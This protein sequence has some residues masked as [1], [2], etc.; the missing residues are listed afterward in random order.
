MKSFI[1]SYYISNTCLLFLYVF[2]RR[3]SSQPSDLLIPD[4]FL[5]ESIA[6]NREVQILA[7]GSVVILAKYLK[8]PTWEAFFMNFFFF[9]KSCFI[10]VLYFSNTWLMLWYINICLICWILFKMPFPVYPHKFTDFKSVSEFDA[11][12]LSTFCSWVILF[13]SPEHLQCITTNSLWCSMSLK[14]STN[15]LKFGKVDVNEGFYIASKCKIDNDNFSNRLPTLIVFNNG[16][17]G[18]RFP[19]EGPNAVINYK[20]KEIVAY[21]GIDRLYLSTRDAVN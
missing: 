1:N 6:S 17:E 16:K 5:P 15:K 18:K 12:V 20:A 8:S 9:A 7:T 21:L 2:F 3:N 14:Y 10:I 11:A 13:Y 19:P 4:D